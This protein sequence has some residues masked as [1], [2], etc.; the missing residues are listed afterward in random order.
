M[1]IHFSDTSFGMRMPRKV[2]IDRNREQCFHVISRVVERRHAFGE[3]EKY[4]FVR[5]MKQ[6]EKF[7]GVKVYSYCV[8]S[9]HFHLM[10][11]VP[12]S[13]KKVSNEEVLKRM[14]YI[15]TAERMEAYEAELNYWKENKQE[16]LIAEF[17]ERMRRRMFCLSTFVK[18]LKQKYTRWFN[19][20]HERKGTLWEERFKCVLMEGKENYLIT[21]F[22]YIELN[23]IRAKIVPKPGE[24]KWTLFSEALDGNTEA[25]KVLGD[26]FKP[27]CHSKWEILKNYITE[28][29][30]DE[31]RHSEI[32]DTEQANT[33][34]SNV[35]NSG[36]E[37]EFQLRIRQLTEGFV[38]GSKEF[39]GEF[40]E[41]KKT[42]LHS[43]RK[44]LCS[45]FLT[46]SS[47]GF[48]SYRDLGK[49]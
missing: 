32:S 33:T 10:V 24:Y 20:E 36:R 18:D 42:Q 17:Y 5:M 8:M 11:S 16:T 6:F 14:G 28:K 22:K 34:A 38:I 41:M 27:Y 47:S 25:Q 35:V 4:Q 15:Y 21:L 26:L 44:K 29:L 30:F 40:F 48:Y 12:A 31:I 23:P 2:L 19:S 13:P 49:G 45:P 1:F 7:S 39:I 43:S 3:R 46:G 37:S 9:N